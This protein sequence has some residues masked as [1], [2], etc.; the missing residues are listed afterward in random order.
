[1][2]RSRGHGRRIRRPCEID[3]RAV[4][5]GEVREPEAAPVDRDAAADE[6]IAGEKHPI[7][8]MLVI[9]TIVSLIGIALVLWID[10]FPPAGATAANDIDT[11]YDVLLIVSVPVF[12]LVMTIAIY[13]VWKFRA[14]PGD[15]RDGP[16]IHG[17]TRLELVWE[18][19]PFIIHSSLAA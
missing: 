10:W 9:G 5:D 4:T 7:G 3:S 11:L 2:Y 17:N 15:M 8:R 1:M 12:V 14:R 19:I 13:C 6:R 18:T 16:P